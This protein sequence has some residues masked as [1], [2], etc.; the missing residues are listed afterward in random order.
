MEGLQYVSDCEHEDDEGE[1][2]TESGLH[3]QWQYCQ[4][5]QDNPRNEKQKLEDVSI[6]V[7][8]H[9]RGRLPRKLD[10]CR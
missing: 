1:A 4:A 9:P 10:L 8:K 6:S 5:G 3:A 7:L 2:G